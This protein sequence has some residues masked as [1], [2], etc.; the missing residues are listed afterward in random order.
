[1]R[2][3]VETTG[4]L[5]RRLKIAVPA[6][7][8]EEQ[9]QERLRSATPQVRLKGFRPGKVPLKEVRRR[10]GK[11][12]RQEVAAD[13]M[14]SSFVEAVQQE[15][16]SPAGAPSL[17]V[18]NLDPGADLE[19]TATFEIF[20]IV[21]V[22]DLSELSVKKPAATVADED[23]DRMV[24]RLREQRTEFEEVDRAAAEGDRLTA[25]FI[26]RVDG[27]PFEGGEGTDVP[28][29]IGAGQMLPD[30]EAGMVG[31]TP[32]E[33]RL[34]PV[35]FPDDYQNEELAG[36]SA[37]FTITAKKI[38]QANVPELDD[39]FFEAMGIEE[40]GE[41]KL[42]A[43]IIENMTSELDNAIAGQVKR[44]V[45]DGL[46]DL[47]DFQIPAAL[48][49]REVQMQK[50][51]MVQ[52]FG[53]GRNVPELPDEIFVDQATR[54]VRVGLV[55]NA[56]IEAQSFEA[57]EQLVRERIE[58]I[59][60]PYEQ[61]EQVIAYY[62]GT[63]ERLQEIE[64]AVLEEQVVDHV[65]ES[66]NVEIVETDYEGVISG[67]AVAPPP[68][69]EPEATPDAEEA[70]TEGADA[71]DDMTAAA[72]ESDVEAGETE[73]SEDAETGSDSDTPDESKDPA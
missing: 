68:P 54:Q 38:E 15:E 45:L 4:G 64:M 43:D 37:E 7:S 55:I 56:I 46:N 3:S 72:V 16:L 23:I 27:E 50:A 18:I 57:D 1:M 33:E 24:E 12:V 61:P 51:R 11:S 41:E 14:Q 58:A 53:Q 42:R 31:M 39:A 20:P 29:T 44:Q 36:K 67:L 65:V 6:E 32:D 8:F 30:F 71:A 21:D 69:V 73:A 47:H 34:V 40:G 25:D 62:Y 22:A 60:Q 70:D 13:L 2:V 49:A 52:Q 26:G 59:A 48:I 35:T 17:D 5:E 9:V 10:F 19:F 63:E 28:V 66:A